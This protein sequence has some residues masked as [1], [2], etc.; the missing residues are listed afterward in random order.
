MLK[1]VFKLI[2]DWSANQIPRWIQKKFFENMTDD[3]ERVERLFKYIEYFMLPQFNAPRNKTKHIFFRLHRCW[4]QMSETKCVGDKFEM[5]V[6]AWRCWW[7]N[8]STKP[9]T[10]VTTTCHRFYNQHL[11]TVTIIM[12]SLPLY[13]HQ[14]HCCFSYAWKLQAAFSTA[15]EHNLG[16]KQLQQRI[17]QMILLLLP[18]KLNSLLRKS[19]YLIIINYNNNLEVTICQKWAN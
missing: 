18:L 15:R 3:L 13:C 16:H 17:H 12:M 10:F 19:F 1:T 8:S 5:R 14:H 2:T 11:Q 6:T 4:W 7:V 9:P